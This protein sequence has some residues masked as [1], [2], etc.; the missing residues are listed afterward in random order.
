MKAG[1]DIVVAWHHSYMSGITRASSQTRAH[2]TPQA[3][4]GC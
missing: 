1:V 4:R 3:A 2:R